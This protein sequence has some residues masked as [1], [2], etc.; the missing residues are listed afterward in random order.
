MRDWNFEKRSSEFWID[1]RLSEEEMNFLNQAI[2][3]E[4]DKVNLNDQ[5]AGNISKSENIID[6]DNWFFKSTLKKLAEKMFYRDW[7]N[8]CEY[9]IEKES[10]PPEFEMNTF[11]VNYQKQHEFNPLHNHTD[12]YSFVIFIKIPTHWKEQHD[13]PFSTHSNSPNASD[14]MF[15]RSEKNSIGC[16]PIPLSPEDEGRMFFF[17]ADLHHLVYPFYGTDKERITISGN[18]RMYDPNVEKVIDTSINKTKLGVRRVPV[19][20]YEE[21][22]RMLKIMENNVKIIKEELRKIGNE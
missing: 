6:K 18:I 11:W 9:H 8:Y 7:D 21:K 20:E 5:L 4:K 10:P 17:S 22:E 3:V 12:L 14:F 1:T 13:L 16:I 19:S 15:V 2:M